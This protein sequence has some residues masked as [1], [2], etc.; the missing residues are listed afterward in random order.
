MNCF[1]KLTR[2]ALLLL[3]LLASGCSLSPVIPVFGAAFPSW[4]FCL[5]AGAFLLILC[6]IFI[7]R[8]G[9]QARFSP[10]VFSYLALLFLFAA[11]LWFLFFAH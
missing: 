6:H 8:K 5:L 1:I 10:L 9:W 3:S 4:F 11:I 2:P 7:V